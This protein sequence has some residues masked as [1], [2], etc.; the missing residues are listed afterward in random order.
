M[1]DIHD[2]MVPN[3]VVCSMNSGVLTADTIDYITKKALQHMTPANLQ[4]AKE[5]A[6]TAMRE[7]NRRGLSDNAMKIAQAAAAASIGPLGPIIVQEAVKQLKAE[8]NRNRLL[9]SST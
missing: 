5:I 2:D 1:D 9:E 3:H 8:M 6:L 7:A 4:A